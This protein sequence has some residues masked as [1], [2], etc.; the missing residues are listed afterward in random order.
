[1]WIFS[2][3]SAS[4]IS[5]GPPVDVLVYGTIGHRAY[6]VPRWVELGVPTSASGVVRDILPTSPSHSNELC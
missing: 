6:F 4:G 3:F 5:Q 2:A 1:M